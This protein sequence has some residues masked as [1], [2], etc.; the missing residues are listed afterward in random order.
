MAKPVS[1]FRKNR[2]LSALPIDEYAR[3]A[4]HF[5]VLTLTAGTILQE[6]GEPTPY[7][8]FPETAILSI[9]AQLEDGNSIER[10]GV[11]NEG[12]VGVSVF[13]GVT[14]APAQVLVQVAGTAV[15]VASRRLR[16]EAA[17]GGGVGEGPP[18]AAT[19]P[20]RSPATAMPSSRRRDRRSRATG[21]TISTRGAP[22]GC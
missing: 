20:T 4:P 6:E 8:Y 16:G 11:G 1:V 9:V 3:L 10:A 18:P 7:V 2:I 19:C 13:L 12:M 15:R 22:A 14:H 5:E 17:R 21:L